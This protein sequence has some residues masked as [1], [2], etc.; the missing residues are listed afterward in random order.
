LS[1]G[2]L[3]YRKQPLE[4]AS[5]QRADLILNLNKGQLADVLQGDLQ[6]IEQAE[7][8]LDVLTKLLGLLSVGIR[9]RPRL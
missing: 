7:G 2:A 9:G 4:H 3:T 6:V 8:N 1:N 5:H